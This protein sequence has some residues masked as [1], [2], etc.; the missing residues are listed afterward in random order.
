MKTKLSFL[1]VLI[2]IYSSSYAEA[3]GRYELYTQA[4]GN[5]F[6]VELKLDNQTGKT[7]VLKNNMF[8]QIA[9]KSEPPAASYKII[10]SPVGDTWSA[11]RLDSDSG[12]TWVLDT[13]IW[14]AI[15]D[16]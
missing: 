10:L 2:S 7:W 12:S 1:F 14:H 4:Y 13:D 5:G 16:K 6:H 3:Q 15:S 11:F 9:E 8:I